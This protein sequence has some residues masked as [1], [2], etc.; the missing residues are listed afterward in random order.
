MAFSPQQQQMILGLARATIRRE[1]GDA[2]AGEP[3]LHDPILRSPAG[4]FVTLHSLLS[5]RLRGCMGRLDSGDALADVVEEMSHAVLD[6]PRFRHT[7]VTLEELPE[8]ELEVSVLS[9]LAAAANATDFDLLTHGIY[10]HCAGE[11]G[12]FLPQVARETGWDKQHLLQRLCA[13]KMG[14]PPDAW[15][16]PDAKLYRFTVDIIGPEPFVNT[17]PQSPPS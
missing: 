12:C 6:D 3:E 1:L 2:Q 14:L 15:Q 8:L 5:R 4:C 17:A 11:T 13:E 10:L 7:P 16:R 9:P